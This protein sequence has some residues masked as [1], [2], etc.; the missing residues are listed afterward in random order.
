M[1]DL[2]EMQDK[3]ESLKGDGSFEDLE[4]MEKM[5]AENTKF[6]NETVKNCLQNLKGAVGYFEGFLVEKISEDVE[7]AENLERQFFGSE[8]TTEDQILYTPKEFS[9]QR[10]NLML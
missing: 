6:Y 4:K 7:N 10:S 1:N 9:D 5:A 8:T 3:F 2:L